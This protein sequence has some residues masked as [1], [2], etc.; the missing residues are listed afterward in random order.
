MWATM[1]YALGG[2]KKNFS[3]AGGVSPVSPQYGEQPT[4]AR[5]R[6]LEEEGEPVEFAPE[7]LEAIR[8]VAEATKTKEEDIIK[9]FKQDRKKGR[10]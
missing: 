10:K 3:P 1:A 8:K 2:V 5:G 6:V 9:E 7:H 4:G